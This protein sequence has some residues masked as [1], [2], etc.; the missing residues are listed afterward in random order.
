[1]PEQASNYRWKAYWPRKMLTSIDF[2]PV[3]DSTAH[4][5]M[6]VELRCK[7]Q[8]VRAEG[9]KKSG[10]RDT[11]GAKAGGNRRVKSWSACHG[12]GA[13]RSQGYIG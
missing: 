5:K 13:S 4:D 11:R 1:M 3:V 7:S 12:S 8:N 6:N 10:F 9:N 2:F